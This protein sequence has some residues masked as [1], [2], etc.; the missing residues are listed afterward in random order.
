MSIEDRLAELEGRVGR[1][2]DRDEI[3]ELAVRYGVVVDDHDAEGLRDLFTDDARWR[4]RNGFVE[5]SGIAEVMQALSGR[6]DLIDTSLHVV[7]GHAVSFE[8]HEPDTATGVLFSH[9]EVTQ[10]GTPM[11]S[12][13]RY[14]DVYR[15][16]DGRWLFA[17]RCLGFYYYVNA[18]TY[19]EDLQSGTPVRVGEAPIVADIP[20]RL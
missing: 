14:D 13:V 16:V 5:A 19:A 8:A 4:W 17:Q 11:M 1:L 9:A 18:R 2:E 20:H 10:Q 6:W 15:R 12:A 7:E 3:T